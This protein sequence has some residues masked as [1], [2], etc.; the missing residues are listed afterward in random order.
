MIS[1]YIHQGMTW[2]DLSSPTRDEIAHILEECSLP[3]LI[4]EE[5]FSGTLHAKVDLYDAFIYL[6]LHFPVRRKHALGEDA[7]TEQEID[8][9]IGKDYLITVHYEHIDSLHDFAKNLE[10]HST[11][12]HSKPFEHAGILFA[13]M[14]KHLYK[15]PLK[16]LVDI[17]HTIRTIEQHIFNDKEAM[18]VKE[19]S[20]TSHALLDFK[21]AIAF[22]EH[23][24][25]SYERAGKRFFGEEYSYHAAVVTAEFN[26][27]Q[28]VLE[29]SRDILS[30]L[31]RTNDS[32]LSTK[33]NSILRIFTV[34][35]FIMMPLTIITGIFGMNTTKEII[36]IQNMHDLY[37]VL[38][39]MTAIGIAMLLIFKLRRWL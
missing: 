3:D 23:I 38:A 13:D 11:A 29:S 22:H 4:G 5:I 7:K 18:T 24:L 17:G 30:E 27:I 15:H 31:Q 8:F 26:K 20:D 39:G 21:Q 25:L 10:T 32:L 34:M 16:E 19:I 36:L 6:I 9:I 14:M 1:H 37:L 28:S 2:I 33:Q 35:T 12:S